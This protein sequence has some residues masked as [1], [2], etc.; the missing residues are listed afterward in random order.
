[1]AKSTSSNPGIPDFLS[2][3]LEVQNELGIHAR[4]AAE[5]VKTA[6]DCNCNLYIPLSEILKRT[7]NQAA[8]QGTP[9]SQEGWVKS[10]ILNI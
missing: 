10:D 1:M 7:G 3:E 6:K 8:T 2:K 9:V 5:I 4:P